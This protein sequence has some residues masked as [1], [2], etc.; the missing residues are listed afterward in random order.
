M[1][2]VLRFNERL[3]VILQDFGEV[4]L[5]FGSAEV[6]QDLLPVGWVLGTHHLTD[7]F[8]K[9][10][11]DFAYIVSAQV[12]LEFSSKDFEGGALSDTIGSNKA[13]NLSRSRSGKPMKLESVGSI[14]VGNLGLEV[15]GEIDDGNSFK[16]TPY[17]NQ[18]EQTSADPTINLL[19]YTYT[20]T[21][22]QELRYESDF[23]RRLHFNAKLA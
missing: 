17:T 1:I 14:S 13:E 3:E 2:D 20:T 18:F 21:D 9:A 19:L 11:T 5:K 16:G 6:F 12:G 4:V 22:T 10:G 7:T 23:V 8:G 15:R